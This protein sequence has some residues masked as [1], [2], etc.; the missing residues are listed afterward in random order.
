[1]HNMH[2]DYAQYAIH[3]QSDH[4]LMQIDFWAMYHMLILHDKS[5]TCI[6][7]CQYQISEKF[8]IK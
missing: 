5:D 7:S 3:V 2:I 8:M 6:K 1:M 4:I